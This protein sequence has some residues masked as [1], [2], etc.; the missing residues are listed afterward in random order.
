MC[1]KEPASVRLECE[2]ARDTLDNL[3]DNDELFVSNLVYIKAAPNVIF[4]KINCCL[5]T[6]LDAEEI[7]D[8]T[9]IS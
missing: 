5:L 1:L 3:S 4:D 6:L 2:P 7:N 8:L 9:N